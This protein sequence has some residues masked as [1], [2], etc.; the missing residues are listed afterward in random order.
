MV[1]FVMTNCNKSNKTKEISMLAIK[2]SSASYNVKIRK[3]LVIHNT[4]LISNKV[5]DSLEVISNKECDSI[6][7]N[8]Y[9]QE[10]Q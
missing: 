10:E 8:I 9:K 4:N 3:Y 7:A 1:I 6:I 2:L 5:L